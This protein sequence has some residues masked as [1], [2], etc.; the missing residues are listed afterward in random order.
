[1]GRAGA[2]LFT[3]LQDGKSQQQGFFTF[4]FKMERTIDVA[5]V[6]MTP[7]RHEFKRRGELGWAIAASGLP[8]HQPGERNGLTAG[9]FS[10]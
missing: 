9:R 10:G 2:K 1:L 8:D 7:W 5:M 3:F 6:I 4:L